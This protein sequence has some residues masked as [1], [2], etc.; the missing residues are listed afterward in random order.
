LHSF[1]TLATTLPLFY[2]PKATNHSSI[3]PRQQTTLILF[4]EGQLYLPHLSS[5]V[6]ASQQLS[7][8]VAITCKIVCPGINK[9]RLPLVISDS[10]LPC[11][12]SIFSHRVAITLGTSQ[13]GRRDCRKWPGG[14]HGVVHLHLPVS[15]PPPLSS[16]N[17]QSSHRRPQDLHHIGASLPTVPSHVICSRSTASA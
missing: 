9:V 3:L 14:G 5:S 17:L 11:P 16:S 6:A 1:L 15:S 13:L 8:S 2:S 12:F 7:S 10:F 4:F